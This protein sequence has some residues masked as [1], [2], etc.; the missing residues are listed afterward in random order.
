MK[1]DILE[2]FTSEICDLFSIKRESF[3]NKSKKRELSDARYL[4]YYL[5]ERR[6]IQLCYIEKYMVENGYHI[7]HSTLRHGIKSVIKKINEDS[8]YETVIRSI[9]RTV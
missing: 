6:K 3:F 4:L 8:D 9:E 1:K 2:H 5:C 7:T